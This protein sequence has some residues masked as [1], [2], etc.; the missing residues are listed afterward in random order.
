MVDISE[1][2][3]KFVYPGEFPPEPQSIVLGEILFDD[4]ESYEISGE[5]IRY[6]NDM[7]ALRLHEGV[8]YNKIVV[9]QRRLHQKYPR[10]FGLEE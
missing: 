7:L 4:G 1:R 6:Q 8:P 5:V 10:L 2:G 9:E 3:I